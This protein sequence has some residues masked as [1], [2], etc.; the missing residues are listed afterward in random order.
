MSTLLAER[1]DRLR[2]IHREWSV[3]VLWLETVMQ[4]ITGDGHPI[5]VSNQSSGIAEGKPREI[6]DET[7]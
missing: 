4:T 3:T 6:A 5:I 1:T 7:G 2:E